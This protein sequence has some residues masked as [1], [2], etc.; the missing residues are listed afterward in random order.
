[1]VSSPPHPALPGRFQVHPRPHCATWLR[2]RSAGLWIGHSGSSRCGRSPGTCKDAAAL[3][4]YPLLPT[5]LGT[6]SDDKAIDEAQEALRR[7]NPP[8]TRLEAWLLPSAFFRAPPCLTTGTVCPLD[9]LLGRALQGSVA[10]SKAYIKKKKKKKSHKKSHTKISRN[11]SNS[12]FKWV[13][14]YKWVNCW[15][16]A[17]S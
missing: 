12:F 10:K 14:I 1:M 3:S 13:K 15:G 5:Y 16:P 11:G 4:R 6:A 17:F 9:F 2:C 8:S 7:P